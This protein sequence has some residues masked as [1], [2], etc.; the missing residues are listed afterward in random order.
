MSATLDPSAWRGFPK[1]RR[2]RKGRPRKHPTPALFYG[3]SAAL[4]AQWT[5]VTPSTARAYKCGLKKPGKSVVTLFELH[6]DRRVLTVEWH[7]WI[8]KPDV[9]VDPEGN[10]TNRNLLRMYQ[11]MMAYAH[12]LARRTG[13]EREIERYYEILKAA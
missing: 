7:G 3:Y 9:I 5:G 10:E 11:M 8:V 4:I 6:R 12:D 13:D 2:L 1:V